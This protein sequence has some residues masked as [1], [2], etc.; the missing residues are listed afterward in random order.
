MGLAPFAAIETRINAA[1][2]AR[3][4]NAIAT[5]NGGDEFGVIFDR[6]PVQTIDGYAESVGPQAAFDIARAP[7]LVYGS[8]LVIDGVDYSVTGGLE[9]DRSGWVT[10]QLRKA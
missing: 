1:V 10:V 6:L 4:S 7:G 3:L 5:F 2:G 9:P 8:V